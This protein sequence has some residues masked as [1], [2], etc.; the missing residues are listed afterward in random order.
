MTDARLRKIAIGLV[1]V[2]GLLAAIGVAEIISDG[3]TTA[4]TS[5]SRPTQDA[6]EQARKGSREPERR[7]G[8]ERSANRE[9]ATSRDQR[10]TQKPERGPT[11]VVTHVVDGDTVELDN[12]KT[13]RLIG[14]DTPEVYGGTECG[15]RQASAYMERIATGRRVSVHTDPTQDTYDRYGRLLAYLDAGETDLG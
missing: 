3:D 5:T 9:Q 13:V 1:V 8:R 14:I 6:A 4:E 7:R 11:A 15:G 2:V 10:A 12:S